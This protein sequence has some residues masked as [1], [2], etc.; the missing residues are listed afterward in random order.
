MKLDRKQFGNQSKTDSEMNSKTPVAQNGKEL[1]SLVNR[2][3]HN[4]AQGVS[5]TAF[6]NPTE[7]FEQE[8]Q[9]PHTYSIS[10]M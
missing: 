10:P 6:P 2:W 4:P 9:V 5:C 8:V 3:L 1:L 7:G